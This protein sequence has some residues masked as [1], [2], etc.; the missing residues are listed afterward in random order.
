MMYLWYIYLI[1]PP[2]LQCFLFA[3]RRDLFASGSIILLHHPTMYRRIHDHEAFVD[4]MSE[5]VSA[6][7]MGVNLK[8]AYY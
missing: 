8:I 7:G 6:L 3:K 1:E 2:S 5:A 4:S